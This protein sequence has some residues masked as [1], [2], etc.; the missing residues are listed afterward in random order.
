M[1]KK[2]VLF[3]AVL[4]FFV[5]GVMA[6]T[7]SDAKVP[8]KNMPAVNA[9]VKIETM[10]EQVVLYTIYRGD[11][12]QAGAQIGQL[13]A[14]AGSKGLKPA[15]PPAFVYLN[16]PQTVGKEHWL[17]EIRIAVDA[18]ALSQAGKLGPYTDVK[19][20]SAIEAAVIDKPVGV[21]DPEQL[22]KQLYKWIYDNGYTA[23]EGPIEVFFTSGQ[24]YAKMKTQIFSPIVRIRAK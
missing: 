14:L 22:Y 2:S 23:S 8:D 12:A 20:I 9:T 21:S 24:D 16:N 15:G 13:Y 18:N 10:P 7:N 4:V 17:T 19:K 6:Q 5:S 11:Y 1:V 3:L